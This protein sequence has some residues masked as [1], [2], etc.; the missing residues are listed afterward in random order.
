MVGEHCFP[1]AKAFVLQVFWLYARYQQIAAVAAIIQFDVGPLA[2]L[3]QFIFGNQGDLATVQELPVSGVVVVAVT[4]QTAILYGG[5]GV[6]GLHGLPGVAGDVDRFE[7]W[8]GL[9]AKP[10]F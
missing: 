8:R 3:F 2:G 5:Y 4:L 9:G 7:C 10:G 6:D 1:N